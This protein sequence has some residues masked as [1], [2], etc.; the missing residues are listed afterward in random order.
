MPRAFLALALTF[1]ATAAPAQSRPAPRA[2]ERYDVVITG[3][4]IVDGSGKARYAGDIGVR[5][6]WIARVAP[7]GGLRTAA[8]TTRLDARGLIVSPG[9]IDVHSHSIEEAFKSPNRSNEAVVRMGVTTVVGG[10]DGFFAPMHMRM[11]M[12]SL[13]H[14]GAGT[15]VAMYVGHNG[16]RE[17]VMGNAQRA[18]TA[19]E[20]AK[21]KALVREGMELGAVGLSSGLMYEPGMWGTTAEVVELAKEVTPFRGIYDS[22]VRDPGHKLIESDRETIE[23]GERA[24]IA[25]KIAHEKVVGLENAGLLDQ[26]IELVESARARGVNAVTDQYPYDGAAT[27]PLE[28][29][30]VVPEAMAK[31]PGF[32]LKASLRDP[33]TRRQ[34]KGPSEHGI[35]GGFAW[36]KATGYSQMRITSSA[37]DPKLVGEYLS[38]LAKKRGVDPFDL[39]SELIVGAKTPIGITLGAV[40][41]VDVKGLLVQP[42]NMIASDGA[43]VGPSE[44]RQGHPRSSGTFPRVLGRYVR[45]QRLLSLEEAMRKMTSFPADFVGLHDRGRIAEGQ[46]ADITIFDART[47]IDRSTWD[48]PAAMATGV[49]HVLVGGTL[50]LRDERMTGEAPGRYLAARH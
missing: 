9:F 19:E 21:M 27:S 25:P 37:D 3:G 16:V 4:T 22:H 8:A 50:V 48:D 42:W 20:L 43:Y 29:I 41:E 7:P 14:H 36:L 5:G 49:K 18:P 24:G 11:V 6:G 1:G 32:D 2:P 17:A 28:G 44:G 38:E 33:A 31:A 10:P 15:N 13:R 12:D 26:V 23:I 39:I 34:L 47:I 46:A 40:R 45:E 30:I 35:D